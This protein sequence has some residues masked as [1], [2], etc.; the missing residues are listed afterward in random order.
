MIL[1]R[2]ILIG[3]L[4][5]AGLAL[6]LWPAIAA[7]AVVWSDSEVDLRWAREGIGLSK[8]FTETERQRAPMHPLKPGYLLYL[9][10][11][12]NAVP[13]VGETRSSVLVQSLLLWASIALTSLLLARSQGAPAGISAYFLLLTFFP[14]RD[15]ASAVMSEAISAAAFLPL[16]AAAIAPPHGRNRAAFVGAAL[17]ALFWVRPNVGGVAFCLVL[18]GWCLARSFRESLWMAATFLVG[19]LGVWV[20]LP[21]FTGSSAKRELQAPLLF[22]SAEYYWAPAAQPRVPAL[23]KPVEPEPIATRLRGNWN[24]L[25]QSPHADRN[26]EM[27]WRAAHALFG[28]EYTTPAGPGRTASST[29]SDESPCPFSCLLLSPQPS[30]VSLAAERP[31]QPGARRGCSALSSRRMFWSD[32]A[33]VSPCR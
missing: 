9:H 25:L 27:R 24:R 14:L 7:P 4:G 1:R 11:A 5:A 21:A 28:V 16:A 6:Y 32:R 17:A 20:A 23:P 15:C 2:R 18:L 26:R 12:A 3:L 8:P 29:T 22:G 10:L 33:H 31:P 13:G 19:L 30:R